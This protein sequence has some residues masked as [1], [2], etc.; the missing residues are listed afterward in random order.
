VLELY[1]IPDK[2][3]A[4]RLPYWAQRH[5][6]HEIRFTNESAFVSAVIPQK[7]LESLRQRKSFSVT[8]RAS[9]VVEQY[10]ASVECDYPTYAVSFVSLDRGGSDL[11]ST[12]LVDVYGC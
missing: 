6:V 11:A 1:F 3:M 4:L 2:A 12:V 5:H 8:G 10:Q 7:E 9:I